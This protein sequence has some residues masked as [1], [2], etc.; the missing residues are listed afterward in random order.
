MI[1][2]IV[3]GAKQIIGLSMIIC[4]GGL[5]VEIVWTA[6]KRRPKNDASN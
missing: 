6:F 3:V 4:F 1:E 2:P 5:L